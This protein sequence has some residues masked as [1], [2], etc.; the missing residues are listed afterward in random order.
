MAKPNKN[1]KQFLK[2]IKKEI[3]QQEKELEIMEYAL[4]FLSANFTNE[5]EETLGI[6]FLELEVFIE[7]WK[8][9]NDR[10]S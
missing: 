7:N 9:K 8:F 10:T 6:G 4:C 5:E 2:E 1:T 3:L